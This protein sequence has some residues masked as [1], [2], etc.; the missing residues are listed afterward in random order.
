[1]ADVGYHAPGREGH[2]AGGPSV[3]VVVYE[4]CNYHLENTRGHVESI[5]KVANISVVFLEV[6][7]LDF[8]HL[9]LLSLLVRGHVEIVVLKFLK[10]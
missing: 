7:L 5:F 1:M 6:V 10:L 9:L 3:I 4:V 2:G 8:N